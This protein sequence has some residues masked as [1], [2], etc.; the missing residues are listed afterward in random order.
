[1][2]R[3]PYTSSI[4]EQIASL[5]NNQATVYPSR[6]QRV[7]FYGNSIS[8][9]NLSFI[10]GEQGQKNNISDER[11]SFICRYGVLI[12]NR[13][14]LNSLSSDEMNFIYNQTSIDIGH[15]F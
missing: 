7:H 5:I 6:N 15:S 14:L 10:S 1:M 13:K 2:S 9:L 12:L 4:S 11:K 8:G 3:P